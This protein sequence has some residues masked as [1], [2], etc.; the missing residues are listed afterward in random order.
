MPASPELPLD[1]I[2]GALMAKRRERRLDQGRAAAEIGVSPSTYRSYEKNT[3]RPSV[4]VF[5]LLS[6]F[7]GLEMEEFLTLYA[8]TVIFALRPAL[9]KELALQGDVA[10]ADTSTN[11]Q[12]EATVAVATIDDE[13][14]EDALDV[15]MSDDADEKGGGEVAMSDDADEEDTLDVAMS[16]DGVEKGA[17]EVGALEVDDEKVERAI[18]TSEDATTPS[19]QSSAPEMVDDESFFEE[20]SDVDVDDDDEMDKEDDET[21]DPDTWGEMATPALSSQFSSFPATSNSSPKKK[22]KK[23]KKR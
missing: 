4:N 8:T 18:Y 16:D 13:D 14:E 10:R 15:A 2:G 12:L 5:P 22:K 23:K 21:S 11:V 20:E 19:P 1:T 7:L 6:K 17:G 9:E 3:Q